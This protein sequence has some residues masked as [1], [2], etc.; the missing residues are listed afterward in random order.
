VRAG[1][2]EIDQPEEGLESAKDLLAQRFGVNVTSTDRA[3]SFGRHA[4]V[5]PEAEPMSELCGA[6]HRGRRCVT[7]SGA[8][9][10]CIMARHE[11]LGSV[12]QNSLAEVF[13][14]ERRRDLVRDSRP[15]QLS[16]RPLHATRAHRPVRVA[17]ILVIAIPR[18]VRQMVN[19]R[20]VS[21]APKPVHVIRMPETVTRRTALQ[22]SALP[23]SLQRK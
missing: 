21:R 9:F 4:A 15:T 8:V 6:C 18:T 22:P 10:P 2:I 7:S 1:L 16:L 3:R 23:T 13:Y 14:R 12:L 11:M 19:V 5:E 20:L 17:R